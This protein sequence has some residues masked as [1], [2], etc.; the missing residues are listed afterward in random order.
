MYDTM[1]VLNF[2]LHSKVGVSSV[3][4]M[5]YAMHS[6]KWLLV[7]LLKIQLSFISKCIKAVSF[8]NAKEIR[9]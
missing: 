1:C 5:M 6:V 4:E 2:P 7:L 3:A 9:M 8:G